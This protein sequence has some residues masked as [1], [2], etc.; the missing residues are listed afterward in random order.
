MSHKKMLDAIITEK[1]GELTD[2][3]RELSTARKLG[4]LSDIR[5]EQGRLGGVVRR[6]TCKARVILTEKMLRE[7]G[8][9][10][11]QTVAKHVMIDVFGRAA[12]TADLGDRFAKKGRQADQ[13]FVLPAME[14]L[15]GNVE[16]VAEYKLDYERF[17]E[18]L[19]FK[20]DMIKMAY[21]SS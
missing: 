16:K 14:K 17:V 19:G 21:S 18:R 13:K 6:A 4:D 3:V 7:L 20:L 11:T 8:I 1:T 5:A 9:E 15:Q 2:A 12:S 10:G